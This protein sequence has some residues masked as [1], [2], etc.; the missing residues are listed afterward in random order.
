MLIE[1][2]PTLKITGARHGPSSVPIYCLTAIKVSPMAAFPIDVD[3][4]EHGLP[5]SADE[6]IG[7]TPGAEDQILPRP[8]RR[9]QPLAVAQMEPAGPFS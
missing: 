7:A 8:R 2:R 9:A 6:G 5:I 1:R 4:T 3:F